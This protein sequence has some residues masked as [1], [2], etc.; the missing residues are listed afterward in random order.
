VAHANIIFDNP[1]T[2]LV[3][4]RDGRFAAGA[5]AEGI[6]GLVGNV[7]EW[8]STPGAC[9]ATP[10]DCRK[11]WNGTDPVDALEVRG[12][13]FRSP[14]APITTAVP[15][16]AQQQTDEVGFRCARSSS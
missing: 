7:W 12:L 9:E 1:D 10:Y 15:Q 2:H 8:T 11:L 13:S 14:V 6:S 3:P 4:V 16:E 5:T